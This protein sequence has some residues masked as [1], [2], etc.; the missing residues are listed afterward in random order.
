MPEHNIQISQKR[1][2]SL[3]IEMAVHDM[4]VILYSLWTQNYCGST[5]VVLLYKNNV[6]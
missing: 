3:L 2:V 4:N 1:T 5:P 6:L